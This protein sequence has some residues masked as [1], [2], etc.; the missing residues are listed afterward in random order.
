MTDSRPPLDLDAYDRYLAGQ[1]TPE[2][3]SA[4]RS[5]LTGAPDALSDT[6]LLRLI[7]REALGMPSADV[8]AGWAALEPTLEPALPPSVVAGDVQHERAEVRRTSRRARR[9]GWLPQITLGAAVVGTIVVALQFRPTPLTSTRPERQY[10][11]KAGQVA[12]ITLPDGARAT[13]APR[14]TL[15][16]MPRDRAGRQDIRL[17]GE[18]YFDVK[19]A[20][21]VPFVVR[22]GSVVARVLGT[23]FGVRH[24]PTDT[25]VQV[26]VVSGKVMVA[27]LTAAHP[28]R[29]LTAGEVARI[30]DS[31]AIPVSADSAM[32]YTAWTD[33][34]LI[35]REVPAS[36]VLATLTRWFGYQ[37]RLADTTLATSPLTAVLDT[38]SPEQ[39]LGTLKLLLDVDLTFDRNV[40]TLHPRGA[41]RVPATERHRT[42]RDKTLIT[43][44]EVG[45]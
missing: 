32:R 10:I 19:A 29:L 44:T 39:A 14:T 11:T 45:R 1:C 15:S 23:A 24:Y 30:N 17:D 9:V 38:K 35:F 27:A 20:S 43:H 25:M 40:V 8:D 18:A 7:R 28:T 31:L 5:F 13:L 6:E 16:V 34:E 37:F 4:V 12:T 21:S 26:A 2:E 42:P 22:T 36:E 3:A 33:G 41:H